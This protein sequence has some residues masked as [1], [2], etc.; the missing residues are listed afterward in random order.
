MREY[1]VKA[2]AI[3]GIEVIE[4]AAGSRSFKKYL[5]R[6]KK[7]PKFR[8]LCKQVEERVRAAFLAELAAAE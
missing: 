7:D 5:A 3:A 4:D 1:E 8:D 6:K 2:L